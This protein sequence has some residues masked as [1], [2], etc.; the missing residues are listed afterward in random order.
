MWLNEIQLEH[1]AQLLKYF[2]RQ[3]LYALV[4]D[5]FACPHCGVEHVDTGRYAKFNHRKH[6]GQPCSK[7]LGLANP[8]LEC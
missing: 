8:V 4:L 3:Q 2:K 6:I 1:A 5:V 7:I